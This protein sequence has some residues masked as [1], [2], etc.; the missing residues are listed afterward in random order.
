[1]AKYYNGHFYV[2]AIPH[3]SGSQRVTFTLAGAPLARPHGT[4][5]LPALPRLA[6][7]VD[8]EGHVQVYAPEPGMPSETVGK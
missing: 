2:F 5:P 4:R 8:T 1:M 3:R 6:V 7:R